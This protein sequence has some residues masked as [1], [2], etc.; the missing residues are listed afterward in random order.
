MKMNQNQ[1]SEEDVKKTRQATESIVEQCQ[2]HVSTCR[3]MYLIHRKSGTLHNS[4]LFSLRQGINNCKIHL[5]N[6]LL[7][8][9]ILMTGTNNVLYSSKIPETSR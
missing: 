7:I 9:T 1:L 6:I 4:N 2:K 5:I 3:T 8:G